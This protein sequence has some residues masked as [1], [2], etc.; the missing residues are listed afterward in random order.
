MTIDEEVGKIEVQ[1]LSNDGK[2]G[3]IAF[4]NR[5]GKM[6]ADIKGSYGLNG[7]KQITMIGEKEKLAGFEIYANEYVVMGASF[8]IAKCNWY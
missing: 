1:T 5:K 6:I 8:K 4:Y 2:I 3:R 7:E